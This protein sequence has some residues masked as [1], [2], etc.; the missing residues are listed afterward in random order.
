MIICFTCSVD[1]TSDAVQAWQHAGRADEVGGIDLPP[2]DLV[3]GQTGARYRDG[4]ELHNFCRACAF[5][6]GLTK[7]PAAPCP[8]CS[9]AT[10]LFKGRGLDGEFFICPRVGGGGHVGRAAANRMIHNAREA[11]MPRS[12]RFA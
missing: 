7:T 5:D 6:L 11:S 12:R 8:T 1:C 3:V 10:V 9:G 4:V 2:V